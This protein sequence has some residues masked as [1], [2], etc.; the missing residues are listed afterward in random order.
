MKRDKCKVMITDRGKNSDQL[1]FLSRCLLL[2][3]LLATPVR[4][5]FNLR[6]QTDL[7]GLDV[8]MYD[9]AAPNTVSNFMDYVTSGAYDGMI[10]HR[11]VMY[12][13]PAATFQPAGTPFVMQTGGYYHDPA[14]GP[15]LAGGAQAIA[16]INPPLVNEFGIS[17]TRATL[18]M[19]KLAN[20][21][22][23]ATYEWFINLTDNSANLD[24]Q[25]G[26]FTVFGEVLNG[27][28]IVDEIYTIGLLRNCAD[29]AFTFNC[30]VFSDMPV[31]DFN[32]LINLDTMIN[33]NAIGIDADGDGAVDAHETAGVGLQHI[34]DAEQVDNPAASITVAAPSAANPLHAFEVLGNTFMLSRPAIRDCALNGVSLDNGL[35]AFTV[36]VAAGGTVDI[37]VT[38]P[39]GE[40]PDT[41]YMYGPVP[42]D[43]NDHWYQFTGAV[44][45]ANVVTLTLTDG[46]QGDA[47][48]VANGSI[49]VAPG[50]PGT[51]TVP[52][53]LADGDCDGVPDTEEDGAANGGN[54]SDA[55]PDKVQTHVASLPNI[56]GDYVSVEAAATSLNLQHVTNSL[57]T[58]LFTGTN[59]APLAGYNIAQGFFQFGVSNVNVGGTADVRLVLNPATGADAFFILSA[60][61]GNLLDHWYDFTFDAASNTGYAVNGNEVLLHLVDGGR[62]DADHSANGVIIVTGGAGELLAASS[63]GGGCSILSGTSSV[64][65]AGAW[66]LLAGFLCVLQFYRRRPC[67]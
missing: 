5:D 43:T 47:D 37:D 40:T 65:R 45:N 17:N 11:S 9:T 16:Q 52:S 24:A 51:V 44:F 23:S 3:A 50:G 36:D 15:F 42:L 57:G 2:G 39:A 10:I 1:V 41:Y 13:D 48:L 67:R 60:E 18:A 34:A 53:V 33:I 35:V 12:T 21:P 8:V 14:S 38:L 56:K 61:P 22:D 66:W 49:R 4:A 46:G 20:D 6:I 54:G 25:N 27:M 59:S 19:A 26:G 63:S 31:V 29:I 55:I 62:G 28:R 58:S 30:G 32:S 7:G 64:H